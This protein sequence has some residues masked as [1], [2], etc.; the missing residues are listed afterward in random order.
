M[1][2]QSDNE[3]TQDSADAGVIVCVSPIN[4]ALVKYWGKIDEE[5][6]LPAN[7]SMSI[8]INK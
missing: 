3:V 8:T 6:I 5:L 4:I 1:E 2:R 7:N